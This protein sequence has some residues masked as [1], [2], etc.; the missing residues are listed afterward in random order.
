MSKFRD[1]I[2]T[3]LLIFWRDIKRILHNPIALIIMIGVCLLPSLYAWYV[4]AANWNPYANTESIKVAVANSDEGAISEYTGQVDIGEQVVD[5]LH[6]DHQL[7]WQFVDEK[8]AIDGVYSGEYYAAIVLPKDFSA[9]F[10]SVFTGDFTQPTIDY[11]V[12]EKYS[13]V[14]PK[15]T[16]AGATAVQKAID[17][18]FVSKVSETVVE[19]TQKV[20]NNVEG[21]AEDAEGSLTESVA[22]AADA[23]TRTR[24]LVEGLQPVI[25]NAQGSVGSARSTLGSLQGQL[26]ELV[27]SLDGSR[28]QLQNIRS[29]AQQYGTEVSKNL[30][31]SSMTLG[32][33][34]A[35]ANAAIGR[36]NGELLKAQSA[37]SNA[38]TDAEAVNARLNA[39]LADSTIPAGDKAQLQTILANQNQTLSSLQDLNAS[40]GNAIDVTDSAMD[41]IDQAVQQGASGMQQGAGTFT[42][43]ILPKITASLDSFATALGDLAGTVRGLEPLLNEAVS[44]LDQMDVTLGQA[45]SAT[46]L[47]VSSIT[48]VQTNLEA[49]LTDLRALQASANKDGLSTYLDI[50][51]DDVAQFMA[52]PVDLKTVA[53]YPVA[54]YG[55]G[56]APFFTNLALWV[57]GFILMAI[58]RLRVDPIGLP[59]FTGVQAYFGRWLLYM[60][61]GLIQAFVVCIGDLVLGVQCENPIAFVGAGLLGVFA[62]VNLMYALAYAFRH[63]GKAIAVLL[64]I[65]QIPGSSGMFPVEMMPAFYQAI[66]PLLPFTYCIDA[67]R[68]AI[69]GFYGLHYLGDMLCL[70][71][72]FIPI[73]FFIGLVIGR[74]DFNLNVLFDE[75]LGKTDL[76]VTENVPDDTPRFRKSTML[77]ALLNT[78]GYRKRVL[79]RA[80]KFKRR[81]P[82]LRR[83]GWI[84]I[85]AQPIIT[86]CVMVLLKADTDVKVVLLVAMVIGIIVVDTYLIVI[87][88]VRADLN[89]QLSLASAESASLTS[90]MREHFN[91]GDDGNSGS[92]STPTRKRTHRHLRSHGRVRARGAHALRSAKTA[93]RA[94]GGEQ[95]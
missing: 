5:K 73:G 80:A 45:D 71:L 48:S 70:A 32:R 42:S 66:H 53:V 82:K 65:M 39:A 17:D 3:I 22:R 34:A 24:E 69:G 88:Y 50:N 55:S 4:I 9:D 59:K 49:S 28:S 77:N 91:G 63:I 26:P 19:I 46:A 95:R 90:T 1:Y 25:K 29:I 44:V 21:N 78:G 68:E 83:I 15:V 93:K 10:I 27:T 57:S 64:L 47:A 51:P 12:N 38:I 87:S 14:A 35:E 81:Y 67:M 72:L 6:D 94:E 75:R 89:Y 2:H 58:I 36:L 40:L 30:T 43:S 41:A 62:Y 7:G 54:N 16:D 76:Y 74:Y 56:V 31:E 20:G 23:I 85:F 13:A 11:Y 86:F 8:Q 33:A 52:S 79:E 92:G 37:L 18:S 60:T 84:A 61:V